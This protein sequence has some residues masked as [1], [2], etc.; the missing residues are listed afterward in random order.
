MSGTHA[1]GLARYSAALAPACWLEASRVPGSQQ[2]ELGL[3][4]GDVAAR[5]RGSAEID[6]AG[7]AAPSRH[8]WPASD[9]CRR[10]AGVCRRHSWS[11]SAKRKKAARHV[12][13][14]NAR[15]LLCQM[16]FPGSLL[17]SMSSRRVL[18]CVLVFVLGLHGLGVGMSKAQGRSHIHL[19]PAR[20]LVLDDV[21]RSHHRTGVDSRVSLWLG[22]SHQVASR[23]HHAAAD[24]TVIV[25]A[26]SAA[27]VAADDGALSLDLV[28]A[29]FIAVLMLAFCWTPAQHSQ[30]RAR[31]ALWQ[32]S[33]AMVRLLDRPPRFA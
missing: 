32:P 2:A 12:D 22:H 13:C 5:D 15:V 21:R 6:R 25:E 31:R 17:Q 33:F 19:E 28:V 1:D 3:E 8:R 23:H 11:P 9:T 20:I 18:V 29:A 24:P 27:D 10:M 30:G 26:L 7:A 4:C 16:F 14:S